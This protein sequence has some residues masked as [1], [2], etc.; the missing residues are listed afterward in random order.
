[1]LVLDAGAFLAVERGDR[2]VMALVK[3]ER[4]SG[5]S[6]VTPGGVVGQ[7]WRSGGGKQA[8]VAMLLAGVEVAHLDDQLG[9]RAGLLLA[10]SGG[11]D[12]IDAA[13]ICLA[14]DGDDVLTSDPGDLKDLA[15]AAGVHV[16]LIPV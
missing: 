13:L 7:V 11:A 9:R 4:N 14:A 10:A 16:E 15:Q 2:D 12:V 1:M 5:R 8:P 6:P 3:R